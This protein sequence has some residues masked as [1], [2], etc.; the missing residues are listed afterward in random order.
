[1]RG[2]CA[3]YAELKCFHLLPNRLSVLTVEKTPHH[4][5]ACGCLSPVCA[6]PL[7]AKRPPHESPQG[8]SRKN[9][10]RPRGLVPGMCVDLHPFSTSAFNNELCARVART[11]SLPTPAGPTA[12][13]RGPVRSTL[14]RGTAPNPRPRPRRGESSHDRA[15]GGGR[16]SPPHTSG[17]SP[18]CPRPG[19]GDA[20]R[21]LPSPQDHTMTAH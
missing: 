12:R 7:C 9:P 15:C 3:Q 21:K 13:G 10:R 18:P 17:P 2:A 14:R 1:M 11:H 20:S 16:P 19:L 8:I 5:T 4:F 6:I